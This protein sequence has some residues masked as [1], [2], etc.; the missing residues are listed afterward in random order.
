MKRSSKI[1]LKV[2]K[3]FSNFLF[4]F[5]VHTEKEQMGREVNSAIW[6]DQKISIKRGK[7]QVCSTPAH[8]CQFSELAFIHSQKLKR[9]QFEVL[10]LVPKEILC[11]GLSYTIFN[12]AF[13]LPVKFYHNVILS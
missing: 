5:L 2:M 11:L 1:L 7:C 10:P 8:L 12:M 4:S 9:N 13:W 3:C 6:K